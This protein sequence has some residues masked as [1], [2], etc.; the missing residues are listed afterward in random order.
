MRALIKRGLNA[1][2]QMSVQVKASM[3]FMAVNFMQKGI[4]FLTAPIFTRLLTTEEY[5]K[6]TVY[7]SWLDVIGIFAM[8]GLCNNVF[9]NGITEFKKDRNNFIF[10]MLT[11]SNIITLC[12]FA[13]VWIVNKYVFRFLNVSDHLILF[14]FFTFLLEPAFEFWKTRQ[15]FDFKYRLLCLFMILVMVCSPVCAITGIFLFP[16]AKVEARI[17]GAQLMTLSICAG[18]YLVTLSRAEGRPRLKYWKYALLYNLPLIPYFLSTYIL[19]S[20]D[21][22][23][24]AHYCGEDKAGIYG[25]AYTMSAVVNIIWSSVNATMIP[26]IYKR[27]EEKRMHTLSEFVNPVIMGYASICIMIM[28]MAP[29][30]IAFLAPSSYGDGMYVIPAIVGGVFYMSIFSIFSNI[31]YFHKKPKFVMG[32]GVAAAVANFLLNMLFIPAVGYFAAGY[33]TL[34]AYLIE[35]LWAYLAMKKVA[36]STVYDIK[37][38]TLMGMGVLATAVVAPLLY[39]YMPVR[40]VLLTVILWYLWTNRNDILGVIWKGRRHDS[41][42]KS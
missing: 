35:V 20:S 17:V 25:I 9:Y 5:G 33:T 31:I 18:C 28:L 29:E 23:M 41:Q 2:S 10:S 3:A 11:L 7:S 27:C 14:M 34:A 26:T 36:G 4:S 22:L 1:F 39:P 37:K 8:F 19:S 13:A 15:R 40:M 38:L 32:A 42:D 24:I 12:V 30:V 16:E 21:R 6:I